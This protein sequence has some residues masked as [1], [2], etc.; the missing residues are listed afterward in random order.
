MRVLVAEDH[1]VLARTIAAGLRRQA[2]AVDI[3]ATGDQAERMCLLTAYDVLILDRDLPVMTGDEVCKAAAG[4]PG[5]SAD[6][7]AD[8]RRRAHGQDPRPHRAWRRRLPAQA[9]R[10]H[11]ARRPRTSPEPSRTKAAAH[12]AALRE[13]HPGRNTAQSIRGRPPAGTHTEGIRGPAP[14]AC[15]RRRA[16][17]A[18]RT[19]P[20]RLGRTPRP[21]HQRGPRHRQ[22]IARQTRRP[23]PDCRR[24]GRGYRLCE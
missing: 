9:L 21:T 2:M 10:L 8:R 5:P 3:A 1:R 12:R 14:A 11:R 7:D 6:P 22:Q 19:R 20:H 18:R 17:T 24:Q 23:R 15:G 4:T 16:G 13:H